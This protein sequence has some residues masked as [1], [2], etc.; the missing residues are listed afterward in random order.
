MADD[1]AVNGG[2]PS[3]PTAEMKQFKRERRKSGSRSPGTADNT[4]VRRWNATRNR[5][6]QPDTYAKPLSS[7][8]T[9]EETSLGA[10]RPAEASPVAAETKVSHGQKLPLRRRPR[11]HGYAEGEDDFAARKDLNVMLYDISQS[12]WLED[13]SNHSIEKVYLTVEGA[14]LE[15]MVTIDIASLCWM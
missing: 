13:P 11:I 2:R 6:N 12:M 3:S 9:W 5:Q 14:K 8:Y 1:K 4:D 10:A 15:E 7:S